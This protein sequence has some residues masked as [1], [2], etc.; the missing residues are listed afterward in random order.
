MLTPEAGGIKNEARTYPC[1]FFLSAAFPGARMTD[2]S[3]E[4]RK[5]YGGDFFDARR[6]RV[7]SL[8]LPPRSGGQ[9]F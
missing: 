4:I 6:S 9:L 1:S 3:T 8:P 7:A 2:D 5:K